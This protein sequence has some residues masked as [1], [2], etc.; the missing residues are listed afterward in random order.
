MSTPIA[1]RVFHFPSTLTIYYHTMPPRPTDIFDTFRRIPLQQQLHRRTPHHQNIPTTSP[2]TTNDRHILPLLGISKKIPTKYPP[3]C[4][5]TTCKRVI[6]ALNKHADQLQRYPR[7]RQHTGYTHIIAEHPNCYGIT[8]KFQKMCTK[9]A[10]LHTSHAHL[11]GSKKINTK[12]HDADCTSKHAHWQRA[13][14]AV[15]SAA[16]TFTTKKLQQFYRHFFRTNPKTRLSQ[17]TLTQQTRMHTT[18]EIHTRTLQHVFITP[19]QRN[20][21]QFTTSR[22]NNLLFSTC[23]HHLLYHPSGTRPQ[24]FATNYSQNL[25]RHSRYMFYDTL[26][27]MKQKAKR[28]DKWNTFKF[29]FLIPQTKKFT[30]NFGRLLQCVRGILMNI[31]HMRHNAPRYTKEK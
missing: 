2:I 4:T 29:N 23:R 8:T 1:G 30:R 22:S 7:M 11:I 17:N 18:R 24:N 5:T 25:L 15:S 28:A 16:L 21:G 13:S 27:T 9:N 31:P 12:P 14:N 26:N 10:L 3:K 20:T 6:N 19:Q